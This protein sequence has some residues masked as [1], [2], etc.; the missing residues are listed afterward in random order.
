MSLRPST[1]GGN[2]MDQLVPW[3]NQAI[4]PKEV[5]RELS[6]PVKRMQVAAEAAKLAM[7]EVAELHTF[8]EWTVASGLRSAALLQACVEPALRDDPAYTEALRERTMVFVA[9]VGKLLQDADIQL[10]QAATQAAARADVRT[11]GEKIL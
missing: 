8:A 7:D 1:E 4:A 5:Q 2:L 6:H 11:T 3:H 10:V 9:T